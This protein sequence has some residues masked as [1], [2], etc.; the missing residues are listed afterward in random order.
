MLYQMYCVTYPLA[1]ISH[2]NR[3]TTKKA[4]KILSTLCQKSN[5]QPP[6][7]PS[8]CSVR[9]VCEVVRIS[10]SALKSRLPA[11]QTS[12]SV[13]TLSSSKYQVPRLPAA[14]R[15]C[16]NLPHRITYLL[17]YRGWCRVVV[18][19]SG[20]LADWEHDPRRRGE[21]L[22]GALTLLGSPQ[23]PYKTFIL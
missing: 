3:L 18:K 12:S 20:T 16:S 6:P 19:K 11:C 21:G 9:I 2:G 1:E 4:H 17:S 10:I 15:S 5:L 22:D 23:P 8:H 13:V 14:P 7:L